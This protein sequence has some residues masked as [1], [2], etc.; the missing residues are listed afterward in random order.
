VNN[1]I[2][3]ALAREHAAALAKSRAKSSP[4]GRFG[5]RHSEGDAEIPPFATP[6]VREVPP[7]AVGDVFEGEVW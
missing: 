6:V 5:P 4:N 1:H 2:S 7:P 3:A